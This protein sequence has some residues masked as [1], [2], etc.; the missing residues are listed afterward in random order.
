MAIMRYTDPFRDLAAMQ[1]RMNR[2]F[3][4]FLG[5]GTAPEE[6]FVPAT[7]APAVDIYETDD[8]VV[9]KAELPGLTREQVDV[10]IRDRVLTLRGERKVEKDVKGESYHRMERA[11]GSFLRS[12]SLPSVV[13]EE[14]I[15]A[16]LDNGVLEI[17]LPKKAE[18]KP[19]QI[20]VAA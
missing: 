19:K 2:V 17:T 7:W 14:K 12:F 3:E 8:S 15:T 1:E 10:E 11:Y 16:K 9:V 20:K 5:R 6:G 4:D 18:A 13:D